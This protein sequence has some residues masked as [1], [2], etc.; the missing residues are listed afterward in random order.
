MAL[1]PEATIVEA[2]TF[3]HLNQIIRHHVE[4]ELHRRH[5]PPIALRVYI[6]SRMVSD[7]RQPQNGTALI[8]WVRAQGAQDV[9][10]RIDRTD[11]FLQPP[12]CAYWLRWD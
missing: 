8:A 2:P 12:Q 4:D 9:D 10:I 5:G 3:S 6:N 7:A 11:K 1:P